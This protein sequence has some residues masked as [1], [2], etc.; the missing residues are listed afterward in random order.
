[1]TKATTDTSGLTL[2]GHHVTAPT[3]P[4]AAVLER[5]PN[6]HPGIAYLVRFA[7]PEF[8]SLCPM[9]GQPDFAHLVI[10]YVPRRLAGR[11]QVAEALSRHPSATT[12]PSTRP[13][14]WRSPAGWWRRWRRP[15]CGSA[16]TGI[17]AAASRSTSSTRP[18]RPRPA[19]GAGPGGAALSWAGLSPRPDPG[20]GDSP[21]LRQ[22][23]ASP[24]RCCRRRCGRGSTPSSRPG[25][26]GHGLAGRARGAAGAAAGAV[27]GGGERRLA[28]PVLRPG[29]G[30]AGGAGAAR[31]R[32]H[33]ASMPR[34][35]GLPR[36]GE[37]RLKALGRWHGAALRRRT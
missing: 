11:E 36:R 7:A 13:A 21:R 17:R 15:G 1:M 28:R 19:L 3:S 10:D 27:A 6:P 16:A 30:P 34:Q 4:E 31:P 26:T 20:R 23:S 9:T 18:A 2:L 35:A 29:R 12:A 14:P 33:L 22:R 5:V 32:R 37:G 25:S 8:T 24:R